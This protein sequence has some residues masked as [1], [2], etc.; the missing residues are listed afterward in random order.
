MITFLKGHVGLAPLERWEPD[1]W[2]NVVE[3][4][5]EDARYLTRELNVPPSF[6]QDIEDVDER[7]RL[8][9]EDDWM[10]MILRVPCKV[11]DTIPF[12]TVPFG[13]ILKEDIFITVCHHRAEMIQDF[14]LYANRKS[15]R[16]AS[17]WDLLFR[18]FLSS[19]VWYLKYLKQISA[20]MS[21]AE[22]EL[23][24][25]IRNEELQRLL[26][27]EKSL[28]FFI[29]S[30]QGND[31]LLA[32][33]KNLKSRRCFF[34]EEL[35]EDVEIEQRQ[36]QDTV[37]IYS[38]ILSGT[39]DAYAS[40]ISNNLNIVMKRMTSVSLI[41]MLPTLIASLYGMNV[42]NGFEGAAWG[43]AAVILVSALVSMVGYLFFRWRR[44]L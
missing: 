37:R 39:M 16:V 4:S 26:K 29:T 19:S 18:L 7:S 13:F 17:T 43:F 23:E 24:R 5:D 44:W 9:T 6:L 11:D 15:V 33:M 41:L 42:P 36:A 38:D 3:P 22:Q 20:Q 28:V 32:R 10:L 31:N 35:M 21:M 1:C 14:V 40:V 8:E 12:I 25:S 30:L 34:D 27:I 2:I